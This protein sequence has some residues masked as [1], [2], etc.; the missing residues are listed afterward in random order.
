[1]VIVGFERKSFSFDDGKTVTGYNIYTTD[2][3]NPKVTGVA[4]ERVFVSDNKLDGYV[5]EVGHNIT[6]LYNKWGK[7]QT[8]RL[9]K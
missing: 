8:F 9:N 2:D 5:P 1:M 6:F 3:S 4:C 7:V